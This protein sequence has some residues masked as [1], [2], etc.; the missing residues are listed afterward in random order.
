M[1]I[2]INEI[3]WAG[4]IADRE[5]QWIELY[6]TGPD[7]IDLSGW[8]LH[9]IYDI[10]YIPLQGTIKT[11]GYFLLARKGHSPFYGVKPTAAVNATAEPL[12][13]I[14]QFFDGPLSQNGEALELLSPDGVVVDRANS[15]KKDKLGH[16]PAGNATTH[17]S[18][19]RS[20]PNVVDNRFAWFTAIS[21]KSNGRDIKQNRICG[22]PG[23]MNWA[24]SVTATPSYTPTRTRTPTPVRTATVRPTYTR[25]FTPTPNRATPSSIVI[26]EFLP[27]PRSDWN[28]DGKVNSGDAYIEIVNLS[29]LPISITGWKLDDQDGDSNPYTIGTILMQPGVHLAFFT[30]QTGILLSTGGDSVRLYKSTGQI[31]DA[32]SYGVAQAPDITWCRLPDGRP[33]WVFGCAPTAG[34]VNRPAGSTLIG[35]RIDSSICLSKTLPVGL[36]MAECNPLGLSMWDASLWDTLTIKYPRFF[37]VNTDLYIM[38]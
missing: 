25:T 1:R 4:T 27:E 18:M 38:E 20:G 33:T 19:E 3:A 2:V 12:I 7:D 13:V 5:A 26:N 30:S 35:N 15:I 10:G 14:D 11:G 36:L 23:Q 17:C 34:G 24:Y 21:A 29:N 8:V 6:N 31:S 32:F 16:W 9:S 28:G 37:D 22:T